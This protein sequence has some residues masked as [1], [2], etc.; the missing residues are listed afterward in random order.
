[1]STDAIVP[2][3]PAPDPTP[4]LSEPVRIID[5]FVAPSKTFTDIRRNAW[6]WGPVVLSILVSVFYVAMVDQKIGFRTVFE[7]TLKLQ[8]KNADRID[9]M[10]PDK[11]EE[12]MQ[13]QAKITGYVSWGFGAI[14][15]IY[16]VVVALILFV[17]FKFGFGSDLTV[18]RTIA[19][20]MYASLPLTLKSLLTAALVAAGVVG[21]GF[22]FQNPI[23]TNLASFLDPA[24]NKF[25]YGIGT[26]L[27]VFYI[28]AL[29]L[30]AIGL[31]YASSLKRQSAYLGVFG[32]ALLVAVGGAAVGAAFS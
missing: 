17:T 20:V 32:W 3:P 1:M 7:N 13:L 25:L 15:I 6:W 27:D 18:S 14:G 21:E 4:G 11:R 10:E 12:A 2:P 19:V 24:G 9:K 23:A 26:N 16:L 31:S 22:T 30:T 28:W 8:P 5:A 29:V